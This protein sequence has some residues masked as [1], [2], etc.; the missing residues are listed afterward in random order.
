MIGTSLALVVKTPT[1]LAFQIDP[2]LSAG[3]PLPIQLLP[4]SGLGRHQKM[5]QIGPLHPCGRNPWLQTGLAPAVRAIW[6][7]KQKNLFV[8]PSSRL[9]NSA[10]VMPENHVRMP[11]LEFSIP[12]SY[13]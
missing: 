11:C 5:A 9:C 3:C 12:A 4:A 6:S 10:S 8:C 2:N 13:S 7:S 1:V